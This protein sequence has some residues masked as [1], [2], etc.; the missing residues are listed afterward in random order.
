MKSCASGDSDALEVNELEY[1]A[2][3]AQAKTPSPPAYKLYPNTSFLLHAS[4]A[5]PLLNTD[6]TPKRSAERCLQK[7]LRTRAASECECL[8]ILESMEPDET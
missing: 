7:E 3:L 1:S 4:R 5:A 6:L 8:R 2:G